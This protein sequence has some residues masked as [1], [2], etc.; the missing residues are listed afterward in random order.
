M[1]AMMRKFDL[2]NTILAP[3]RIALPDGAGVRG[4]F[5]AL[6]VANLKSMVDPALS[7]R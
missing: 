2:G 1:A 6:S 7:D 4:D 5:S 3:I